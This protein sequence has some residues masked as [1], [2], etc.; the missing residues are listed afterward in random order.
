MSLKFICPGCR[1]RFA[2]AL[3]ETGARKDCPHCKASVAMPR[4]PLSVG[5]V[6]GDF[7][8]CGAV[9]AGRD[10]SI[11]MA[12]DTTTGKLVALR[13]P[14]DH[15][16][17]GRENLGVFYDQ[18]TRLQ[19]FEHPHLAGVVFSGRINDVCFYAMEYCGGGSLAEHLRLGPLDETRTL[20]ILEQLADGLA[21]LHRCQ[22]I[23]RDLT[24]SKVMFDEADDARW[25]DMALAHPLFAEDDPHPHPA[26][27]GT[28]AYISPEQARGDRV[29]ARANL[30]SLGAM[31]FHML[32]GRPP[33]E[34]PTD[35]ETVIAHSTEPAPDPRAFAPVSDSLAAIVQKLLAKDPADR[36]QS[37]VELLTALGSPRAAAQATM[38]PSLKTSAPRVFHLVSPPRPKVVATQPPMPAGVRPAV[39]PRP[40]SAKTQS[41]SRAPL[42]KKPNPYL[43]VLAF[44]GMILMVP[45]LGG[46]LWW[47]VH[48]L[49]KRHESPPAVT[50]APTPA[51]LAF[52]MPPLE[53]EPESK[54]PAPSAKPSP[55]PQPAKAKAMKAPSKKSQGKRPSQPAA[56]RPSRPPQTLADSPLKLRAA[57]AICHGRKLKYEKKTD[58]DNIG[59]WND[60]AEWVEWPLNV[61]RAGRFQVTA[62][63][64]S[65]GAGSFEIVVGDAKLKA[66]APKTGD[67]GKFQS[68]ELGTLKLD[69]PGNV[70]LAAKPIRAGW[71]PVNL[72]SLELKPEK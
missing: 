46:L 50:V 45:L 36:F 7:A 68:V 65:V 3:E 47:R 58:R 24:P 23:P 66:T 33:F 71:S 59:Y 20:Q 57:D 11:H 55:P 51:D 21:Y 13:I 16:I 60:P 22:F 72:K 27:H 6:L 12:Q 43:V 31:A 26:L 63:I 35:L 48:R 54:K 69:K 10:G 44:V 70:S 18:M 49:E 62:E 17:G 1:K 19:A 56:K 15:V 42:E 37:A 67:Y 14:N 30:Y 28:P 61:T 2:V 53:P 41:A 39:V 4:N 29:D 8:I 64:A 5:Y 38:E 52:P 9:G 25:S 34:K 40:V 32:T